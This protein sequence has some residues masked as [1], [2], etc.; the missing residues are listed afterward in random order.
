M[1]LKYL[2]NE[3]DELKYLNS[4]KKNII[5]LIKIRM[6]KNRIDKFIDIK[7]KEQANIIYNKT[8]EVYKELIN[9]NS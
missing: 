1:D 9:T 5:N 6:C 7:A 2:M 3:I 8:V 4:Q